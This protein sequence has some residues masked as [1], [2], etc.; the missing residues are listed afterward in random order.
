[1]DWRV[2]WGVC[3]GLLNIKS[4]ELNKLDVSMPDSASSRNDKM[5]ENLMAT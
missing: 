2:D 1:M 3:A 5:L 4:A